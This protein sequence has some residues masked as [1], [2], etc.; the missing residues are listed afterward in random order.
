MQSRMKSWG[1][2]WGGL[3]LVVALLLTG[4]GSSGS[5]VAPAQDAGTPMDAGA[6]EMDAGTD[7]G[8]TDAGTPDSGVAEALP[9]EKHLGVC[10]GA[11]RAWVDGAYEPVCT[12]RSYGADYETS[13]TRC[14]GLDNDCDGETDPP[15]WADA[16][17]MQWAPS[18]SWTDSLPVE[19]GFLFVSSDGLSAIQLL[20]LDMTLT[21]RSTV[22]LPL[23]RAPIRVTGAQ[24]V[25]TAR[26]PAL[27]FIVLYSEPDYLTQA[28]LVHLDEQGN[29]IGAPEG[30]VIFEGPYTWAWAHMAASLDGERLA[31]AWTWE[32]AGAREVQGMV[33]DAAGQVL[34]SSRVL[35][36]S[37][38]LNLSAAEVLALE[39]GGFLV[40]ANEN[41]NS[42]DDTR[43]WMRRHDRELAPVGDERTLT[44]K[45]GAL[46]R[47]LLTAPAEEGGP[48]EPTLLYREPNGLTPQVMQVRSLFNGG[49]PELLCG[50]KQSQ[51][52]L[53]GATMTSRGLQLAWLN[54]LSTPANGRDPMFSWEGR[55][56]S[57]RPSP[58]SSTGV[59]TEWTPDPI[60][61]HS[62]A[63]WVRLHELPGHQLGILMMTAKDNPKT[64]T[65]RS[66]RYCA[67]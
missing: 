43:V 33:V 64:Y 28:R 45:Y 34:A 15:T 22:N 36:R 47:L 39:D 61:L 65:L 56:W 53:F 37:A 48:K 16:S 26:G 13:E 7:A 19:G 5:P 51:T 41:T 38:T 44:A 25:R 46:P 55:L 62:A 9:C 20:R 35:H 10:A 66:L 12:A 17:P 6:Q 49:M 32:L 18:E 40:K 27:F 52:S 57:W 23:T 54:M 30:V 67:P 1:S 31:V 58:L 42:F 29:P 14:D 11:K 24:L 8:V 63:S 3:S 59:P 4:C 21:P 2:M 60:P 50:T